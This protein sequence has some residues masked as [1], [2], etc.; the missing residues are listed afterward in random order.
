MRV[1]DRPCCSLWNYKRHHVTYS[2]YSPHD[3]IGCKST[4]G[5][6]QPGSRVDSGHVLAAFDSLCIGF[7]RVHYLPHT[8]LHEQ[9]TYCLPEEN[10][11]ITN[12]LGWIQS[13]VDHNALLC[14]RMLIK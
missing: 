13:G 4:A 6:L 9:V 1:Y 12:A 14:F 8:L 7:G 5:F 10:R 2:S 11:R 3:I